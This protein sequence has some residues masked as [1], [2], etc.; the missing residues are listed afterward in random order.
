MHTMRRVRFFLNTLT[1]VSISVSAPTNIIPAN[2]ANNAPKPLYAV[3]CAETV[4]GK[5]E[6][7]QVAI[8]AFLYLLSIY[9]KVRRSFHIYIQI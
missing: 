6:A 5:A 4:A 2:M 3:L 9:A 7:I 1:I 8:I